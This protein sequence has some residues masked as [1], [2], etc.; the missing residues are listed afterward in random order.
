MIFKFF[1]SKK[2]DPHPGMADI[3][4]RFPEWPGRAMERWPA[5][6]KKLAIGQ[7]VTGE[8]IADMSSGIWLD[9]GLSFPALLHFFNREDT[10]EGPPRM[11][12]NP[13]VGTTIDCRIRQFSNGEIWVTQRE[14]TD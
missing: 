14:H 13:A 2:K 5:E 4:K 8:V 12:D 3:R 1:V 6:K 10:S 11:S 7:E 9:I